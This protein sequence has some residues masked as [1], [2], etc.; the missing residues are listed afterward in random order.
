MAKE[1][2]NVKLVDTLFKTYLILKAK[3]DGSYESF[4]SKVS[5]PESAYL[6]SQRYL[7]DEKSLGYRY[8]KC[9]IAEVLSKK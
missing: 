1:N 5:R 2:Y 6:S 4:W 9:K 8:L 3:E 7:R